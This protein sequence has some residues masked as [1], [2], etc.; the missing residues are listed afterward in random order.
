MFSKKQHIT[1][2]CLVLCLSM[3]ALA[4]C[5]NNNTN[6]PTPQNSTPP[7]TD[8]N[9][10]TPAPDENGDN[11]T[12]DADGAN[13]AAD[14][15]TDGTGSDQSQSDLTENRDMSERAEKIAKA[16]VDGVDDVEDANVLISEHVA[17]AAIKIKATDEKGD[18]E[19]AKKAAITKA[20]EADSE[21]TDVYVS[22]SADVFTRV[23]EMGDAIGEG[24]PISGFVE[25]LENL[26]IRVTPS[27]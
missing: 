25:E 10:T 14:G 21:L 20:K 19:A 6:Q 12:D 13:D 1:T 7:A 5:G 9:M 11:T 18:A 8:Q 4:G 27:N 22:E 2:I 16:I 23:K 17:Y 24:K 15:Q 3:L 26:F